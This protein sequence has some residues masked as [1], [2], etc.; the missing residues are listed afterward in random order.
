[1]TNRRIL[2]MGVSGSGKSYVGRLLAERLDAAFI[3]GDDHHAPAS[4]DKM[5]RGIPLTDDDRSDWL[6]TLAGL[7]ADHRRRGLPL[8]VACSA[9]KRRYRDILRGGDPSLAILFL[10]GN[11][12][13]LRERLQAR[14]DHFFRGDAMLE[15]QLADLEPPGADEAVTLSIELSP[16]ALVERFL[17]GR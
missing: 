17:A 6:A 4:I 2:V 3:D 14:P 11:R 13:R 8:V 9:L 7:I 5:R 15:S 1:M 10:D 16:G 12:E